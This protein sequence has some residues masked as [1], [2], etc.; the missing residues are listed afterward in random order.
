MKLTKSLL[1]LYS[2]AFISSEIVLACLDGAAINRNGEIARN[3]G[4]VSVILS[5]PI[6]CL[7]IWRRG[8]SFPTVAL[9]VTTALFHVCNPGLHYYGLRG[10]CGY[11]DVRDAKLV[12]GFTGLLLLFQLFATTKCLL[13]NRNG[14]NQPAAI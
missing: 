12:A 10:D 11:G 13:T 1:L 4:N 3:W 14:H 9:I 8:F 5:V 7:Q 6:L 2:F